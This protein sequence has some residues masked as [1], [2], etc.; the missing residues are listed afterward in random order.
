MVFKKGDLV[1]T[2]HGW[3]GVVIRSAPLAGLHDKAI[4]YVMYKQDNME[5]EHSFYQRDLILMSDYVEPLNDNEYN[6]VFACQEAMDA[7]K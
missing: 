7:L 1:K 6:E 4:V 2:P 3:N 5:L